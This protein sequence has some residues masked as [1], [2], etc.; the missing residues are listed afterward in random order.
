MADRFLAADIGADLFHPGPAPLARQESLDRSVVRA[1]AGG[2]ARKPAAVA[3]RSCRRGRECA[4]NGWG[5]VNRPLSRL[6]SGR[7]AGDRAQHA[8]R[9]GWRYP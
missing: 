7:G 4:E 3:V 2:G 1:V 9:G 5:S 8:A 6:C